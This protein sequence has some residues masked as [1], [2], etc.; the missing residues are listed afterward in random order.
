MSEAQSVNE[1]TFDISIVIPCYNEEKNIAKS[2]KKLICYLQAQS[3]KSEIIIGNDGSNDNTV[4]QSEKAFFINQWDSYLIVEH[5]PNRGRGSILKKTF[6]KARGKFVVYMDADLATNLNHINDMMKI[7]NEGVP[8]VTGSR[9]LP[10]SK[11][12]RPILR[13]ILSRGYN[14][15]VRLFFWDG[16]KDHQC[17]FKGM[18]YRV[19]P[20][21]FQ[22][23]ESKGWFWDTETL[24]LSKKL[25]GFEV[26]E[27]AIHWT[28][29]RGKKESKVNI[30]NT[31][32]NYIT[33]V[34]WLRKKLWRLRNQGYLA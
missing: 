17:G 13:E 18:D 19:I 31:I 15:L 12:S 21:I 1:P 34:F 30:L 23:V 5:F 27:I 6:Q 7:L 4:P 14:Q 32:Q 25:L 9:L 11:V 26:R 28:E 24:I 3:W 10:E 20:Q 16:I 29:Y 2:I 8:V 22:I 33:K